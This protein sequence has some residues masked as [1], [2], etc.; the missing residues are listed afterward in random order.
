MKYI[1]GGLGG[2]VVKKKNTG[3]SPLPGLRGAPGGTLP[4][5]R[6]E[7]PDLKRCPVCPF[8]GARHERRLS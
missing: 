5:S 1:R 2:G 8:T 3:R 7:F 6:S 4:G